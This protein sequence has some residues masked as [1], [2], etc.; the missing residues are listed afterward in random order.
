MRCLRFDPGSSQALAAL[1]GL[2]TRQSMWAEL[3][4]N[5]EV[6]LNLAET[7]EEQL[8]L[9]LRLASLR[10]QKM[11][12]VELAIEGYRQVLERDAQNESALSALERLGQAEEH[13]LQIAEIL[14]PLYRDAGDFRKLIGV[15]EVQVRRAEESGRK[16]EL[17]QEIA[18]LYEDAANEPDAAFDTMARALAV[19]PENEGTQMALDRL[20]RVTG[21]LEAL[22]QVFEQLADAQAEP[23]HASRLTTAAARVYES[24]VQNVEKAIELYRKVL[25]IDPMN[26]AAAESL[27]SL[28]QVTGRYAD[29]SLIL[30]RKA[31]IL[32]ITDEQKAA[33]YEAARIEEEVLDRRESAIG[34]YLKVLELDSEDLKSID[35]LIGLYIGLSRWEEL[36]SVYSRKADLVL[37]SDEKKLIY[38]QVGAVYEREL[39]DVARAIDTYQKVL[40][41]DPDD[42]EALGR[43]DVLYQTANN[44]QELLSVLTHE[45]ELLCRSCRS[46]ELPVSNRGNLRSSVGGLGTCRGALSRDPRDSAGAPSDAR[47]SRSDKVWRQGSSGCCQRTRARVRQFR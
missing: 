7:D 36:L 10:E 39:G 44:W 1:D 42:M 38:Y 20:A 33:L 47:R 32:D 19:D 24:D 29:M 12:E 5:L 46:G 45:A 18:S 14:E 16:V 41:L 15:H 34:V 22:A 27:Q 4:E 8:A 26:L 25:S 30:Q 17:L 11:G 2:F 37:D 6:Q 13:E 43:L 21:R 31:E 28:F 35:A 23:E 3:A 40:E 9:M